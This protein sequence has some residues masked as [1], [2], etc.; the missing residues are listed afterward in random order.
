VGIDTFHFLRPIWFL[1][2]I[3]AFVL[4]FFLLRRH[5]SESAWEACVD[6]NL[7]QHLWLQK[8]GKLRRLPIILLGL[9]WLLAVIALAGPV[10]ERQPQPVFQ[11][12]MA[13][14]IVLD[15]SASMDA[16]D[17]KP[18]RLMRARFKII[19]IL[20]RSREGRTALV[21]FAAEPHLVTPLT[22]DIATLTSM[23]PALATDIMPTQGNSGTAAA[24]QLAVTL[25]KNGEEPHGEILLITDGIEDQAAMIT[26]VR[27]LH[28]EGY[29]LSILGIGSEKSVTFKDK[30]QRSQTTAELNSR[31]L[32]E[33]ATI[34]GGQYSDQTADE[35]D[36]E[37]VLMSTAKLQ[38]K[39]RKEESGGVERWVER[40]GWLLPIILFLAASGFRR[41]WLG[42]F[43]CG[44]FVVPPPVQAWE[45]SDLWLNADQQ[46]QRTLKKG[47]P[48]QAIQQF[49]DSAWKGVAQYEAGDYKASAKT[50]EQLDS[51]A[52]Q[53]NY[54]NALARNGQ[55]EE[56]VQ[57]YQDTLTKAPDFKDAKTNL[58]LVEALLKQQQEQ[59]NK[60]Q[61][62]KGKDN[63]KDEKQKSDSQQ[64]DKDHKDKNQ[65]QQ[66]D[67]SQ[68]DSKQQQNVEKGGED[69][70]NQPEDNARQD[71]AA[72]VKQDVEDSKQA[73]KQ[74][75]KEKNQSAQHDEQ[76]KPPK[77]GGNDESDP[78]D[79]N[80]AQE[81]DKA[82]QESEGQK[83]E[84]DIA[85]EQ[86]LQQI[87]DDPGG[88]LRRKFML[89][90]INRQQGRGV[91]Q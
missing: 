68:Q 30:T 61:Q 33:M 24:L 76:E 62:G 70:K 25:L 75:G 34:G 53:Y 36:L 69:Q 41:G 43:L 87:P 78:E 21:V 58:K 1:A 19:D 26:S 37:R 80:S 5:L 46:A 63:E 6:K 9:G 51:A 16:T 66:A 65:D 40:G 35:T 77:T 83:N 90:Y 38:M 49:K 50:F 67:N 54:G 27:A 85:L 42:I 79:S 14:V 84:K 29:R 2:L 28:S 47:N 82:K 4:V 89:E 48:K 3:P 32:N 31:V 73:Q 52:D 23:L 56:A 71:S 64:G 86:W 13:R 59:K 60:D 39:I 45:W 74:S 22:D 91:P 88:L 55:L 7:L 57:A 20:N 81:P 10:W 17:I 15:L 18:S 72:E 8:P 11:T 44:I 12:Q